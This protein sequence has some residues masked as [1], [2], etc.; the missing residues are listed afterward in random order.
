MVTKLLVVPYL[1]VATLGGCRQ[2]DSCARLRQALCDRSG[3]S[4][5]AVGAW[6]DDQMIGPDGEKLSG[7]RSARACDLI[8]DSGDA[9][10]SYVEKARVDLAAGR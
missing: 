7:E 3:V 1:L 2:E 6:L 9:L 8:L 10:T 4:C 5:A